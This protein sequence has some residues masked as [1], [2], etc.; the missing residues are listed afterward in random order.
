MHNVSGPIFS[1]LQSSF[2]LSNIGRGTHIAC[3]E[4]IAYQNGFITK[5]QLAERGKLVEKT[6]YGQYLL[7][8]AAIS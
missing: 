8:L 2:V 6:K 3:L 5:E 1:R 7:K 4:E